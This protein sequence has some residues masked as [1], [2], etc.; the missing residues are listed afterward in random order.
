MASW[1]QM[2]WTIAQ[3]TDDCHLMDNGED[4]IVV[5]NG[6]GRAY[7]YDTSLDSSTSIWDYGLPDPFEGQ[8]S[9]WQP[10]A[11]RDGKLYVVTNTISPSSG[12]FDIYEGVRVSFGS[13]TWT[14]VYNTT[15]ADPAAG[16]NLKTAHI[17]Y[18]KDYDQIVCSLFNTYQPGAPNYDAEYE[19]AYSSDGSSWTSTGTFDKTIMLGASQ[20]DG[21]RPGY[22]YGE[23]SSHDLVRE[24]YYDK[25]PASSIWQSSMF[26]WGGTGWTAQCVEAE[27]FQDFSPY[28]TLSTGGVDWYAENTGIPDTYAYST[29]IC[30]GSPTSSDTG[31][32]VNAIHCINQQGLGWGL[33]A[34]S[35]D[36]KLFE[37]T[38]SI[39]ELHS[40]VDSPNPKPLF[41]TTPHYSYMVW[42][43]DNVPIL[44]VGIGGTSYFHT[45]SEPITRSVDGTRLWVYKSTDKG[46]TWSSRGVQTA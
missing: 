40:T 31:D 5:T 45:Y 14:S 27:R 12:E 44:V 2:G 15:V 18:S 16:S 28:Y 23:S 39:W 30:D 10:M 26:R 11:Y 17:A 24:F 32:Y 34:D 43:S 37:W 1:S 38:G 42:K 19:V 3:Y 7:E 36:I 29:S 9:F 21:V 4:L 20:H 25:T 33:S 13:W 22:L 35:G 46:S 6:N 41:E 8:P